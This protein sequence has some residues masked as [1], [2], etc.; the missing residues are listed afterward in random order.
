VWKRG[1]RIGSSHV[2]AGTTRPT[3]GGSS[4]T[5]GQK[6]SS[7]SSAAAI[8]T[9]AASSSPATGAPS[10]TLPVTSSAARRP[11]NAS[12]NSSL[13][14]HRGSGRPRR[15]RGGLCSMAYLKNSPSTRERGSRGRDPRAGPSHCVQSCTISVTDAVSSDRTR[16]T[17]LTPD[18]GQRPR[19]SH[20]SQVQKGK[21][22]HRSTSP[23]SLLNRATV[24]RNISTKSESGRR[25]LDHC[26]SP[27]VDNIRDRQLKSSFAPPRALRNM[28]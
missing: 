22:M 5:A 3:F 18:I 6:R 13:T 4:S 16:P 15:C 17:R 14:S 7:A 10:V 24:G 21:V 19:G 20:E 12:K 1:I 23:A 11:L 25:T 9:A 2:P 26:P 28:G 27:R 8:N